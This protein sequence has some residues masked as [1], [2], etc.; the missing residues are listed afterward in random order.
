ME[1]ISSSLLQTLSTGKVGPQVLAFVRESMHEMQ[2]G[3]SEV[4]EDTESKKLPAG[5]QTE[6]SALF[7]AV[8]SSITQIQ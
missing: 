3:L 5:N 4:A 7:A 8:S 2:R 6:P 1:D